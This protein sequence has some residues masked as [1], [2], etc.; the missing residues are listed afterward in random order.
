MMGSESR[1][2]S[3]SG[4]ESGTRDEGVAGFAKIKL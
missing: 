3:R 4:R 1:N 2:D